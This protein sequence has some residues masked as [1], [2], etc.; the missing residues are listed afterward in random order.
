MTEAESLLT[1]IRKGDS[2]ERDLE[3]KAGVFL[4]GVVVV[5]VGGFKMIDE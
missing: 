2:D 3:E 5:A 4:G 1:S